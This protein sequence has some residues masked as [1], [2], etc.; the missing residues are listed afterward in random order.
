MNKILFFIA[1]TVILS[2]LLRYYVSFNEDIIYIRGGEFKK[3]PE[4]SIES[5]ILHKEKEVYDHLLSSSNN[6]YLHFSVK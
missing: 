1:L 5:T 6:L 2:I 4:I 3:E